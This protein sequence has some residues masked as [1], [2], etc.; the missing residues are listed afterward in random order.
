MVAGSSPATP[1]KFRRPSRNARP[2]SFLLL[3]FSG[4][5]ALSFQSEID[6]IESLRDQNCDAII[7]HSE[8]SDEST[9][10]GL[11]EQ[12]PGLVIIN[13]F[14]PKIAERSVWL[15]NVTSAKRRLTTYSTAAIKILR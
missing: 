3:I 7:L 8:Y 11:T 13:R 15:D 1:A 4:K 10:I 6:A 2:L 14:I 12:I 5:S 9:L